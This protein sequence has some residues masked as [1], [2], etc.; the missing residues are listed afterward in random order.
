MKRVAVRACA[1]C[2]MFMASALAQTRFTDDA[3][4]EVMLPARVTRLMAAGAPAD[5][6]LYTLAPEMLVGRNRVPDGDALEFFPARYRNP[7]PITQLPEVDDPAADA[8][9]LKLKPDVYVDYGTIDQDY[10]A[11]ADAVQRRTKVPSLLLDGV[12]DSIPQAYRRLGA[13]LGIGARGEQLG[14]A[15]DRLLT[16]YRNT[17]ASSP[18]RVYVAC[19]ADGY[20]PCYANDR[21]VEHLAWLGGLNVAG[22]PPVPP[23][24]PLTIEQI[25]AL[26]PQVIVTSGAPGSAARLRS[27][28]AWQTLEAVQAGRVHSWPS[29]PFSWGSRPPSVNRLPGVIWLAYVAAGRPFDAAFTDQIRRFY[30]D[31][32]HLDL[33]DA[34]LRTLLS[35]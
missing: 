14:A 26:K 9:L 33:T 15:A 24:R 17:L 21:G 32:Y 28:P 34:Q 20:S 13:A 19:S 16:T 7:A 6:L 30:Q 23:R 5:V 1:G 10:V 18:P 4:R 22:P 12:L 3:G 35:D 8:D 11:V 29:F 2:L 25:R 27:D 31:F